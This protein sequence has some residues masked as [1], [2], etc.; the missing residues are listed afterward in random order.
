MKSG[1]NNDSFN[2]K[3]DPKT[4]EAV[5]ED[6]R[7]QCMRCCWVVLDTP[8]TTLN[9]CAEGS[10]YLKVLFEKM[11]APELA[12]KKKAEAERIRGARGKFHASRKKVKALMKYKGE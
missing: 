6:H 10:Q 2:S 7:M 4:I 8:V 5:W 3:L 9:S 11:R 12:A 1:I